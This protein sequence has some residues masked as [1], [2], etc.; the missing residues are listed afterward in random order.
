MSYMS[1]WYVTLAVLN[2]WNQSIMVQSPA[3]FFQFDDFIVCFI[4]LTEES[5]ETQEAGDN[6]TKNSIYKMPRPG[7][8]RSSHQRSKTNDENTN[9]WSPVVRLSPVCLY[10][11]SHYHLLQKHWANFI[12]TSHKSI[13][14]W[15]KMFPFCSNKW[16]CPF[17]RGDNYE[18]TKIHWQNFE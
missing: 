2:L 3:F 4:F 12:Q 11:L 9:S 7:R 17:P 6:D 10:F 18:K 8:L 5:A 14:G 15:V 1:H 16:S 13:L